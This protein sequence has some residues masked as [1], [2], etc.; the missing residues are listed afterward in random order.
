MIK[1]LTITNHL[2]K[3]LKVTLSEAVPSH[4]LLIKSITGIGPADAVV[5]MSDY[6]TNDGSEFNSARLEKRSIQIIFMVTANEYITVEKARHI[7]Y[8]MFPTKKQIKLLFET[9]ER[10]LYCYGRVEHNTPDIFQ[11]QELITIDIICPNPYFYKQKENASDGKVSISTVEPTFEFPFFTNAS[12][13][14]DPILDNNSYNILDSYGDNI[15]TEKIVPDNNLE[16]G[17]YISSTEMIVPI[18]Y[19]G[20]VEAPLLITIK[21]Y[22]TLTGNIVIVDYRTKEFLKLNVS[23]IEALIG[24]SI[25]SGDEIVIST[26]EKNRY[27]N[28]I[29][30]GN[31][32]NILNS[33]DLDN[34]TWLQLKQGNNVIQY[35]VEEGENDTEISFEYDT[36]FVGV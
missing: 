3:E 1:S 12:Y 18:D 32:I 28:L 10:S 25:T 13:V 15:C 33:V 31:A 27:V 22:G 35:V 20:D 4:G 5:N 14:E 23:K 2:G 9:D 21:N 36:L 30:D 24:G 17:R 8:E 19:Y 29:K 11:K 7:A 34:S 6:A 26:N 16:M